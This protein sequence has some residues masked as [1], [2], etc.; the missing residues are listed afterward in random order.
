MLRLK[1][2]SISIVMLAAGRGT[3]ME[4]AGVPKMLLPLEGG[5]SLVR[6]AVRNALAMV[7]REMVVV[8]RPDLA[9]VVDALRELPVRCVENRRYME[10]MGTS[11]AVGIAALDR[12]TTAALVMLGDEPAVHGSIVQALVDAYLREGKAITTP[13]YGGQHGPPTL[14]S[15]ELFGE[16]SRLEG[17]SGGRQVITRHPEMVCTVELGADDRPR[18]IDTPEDYRGIREGL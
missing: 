4:A 6:S 2:H 13:M 14:F 8:V 7:P 9:G 17:D 5:D 18:D 11:L 3:R 16:L 12:E 15:R 10:G 1:D